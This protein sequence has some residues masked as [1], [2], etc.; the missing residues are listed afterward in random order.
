MTNRSLDDQIECLA[1]LCKDV[2]LLEEADWLL[3]KG[4]SEKKLTNA[5]HVLDIART[6]GLPDAH[7][8]LM[9]LMVLGD[10]C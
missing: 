9:D 5:V 7:Q 1:G 8:W 3:H 4:W 10:R 2:E 6:Y